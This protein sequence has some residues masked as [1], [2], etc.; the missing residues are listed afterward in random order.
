MLNSVKCG[1][2]FTPCATII[3]WYTGVQYYKKKHYGCVHVQSTDDDRQIYEL[4][5]KLY[6]QK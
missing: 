1:V 6:D 2:R 5:L 3:L 4:V